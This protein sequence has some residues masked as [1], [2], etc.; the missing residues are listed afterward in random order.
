MRK[1]FKTKAYTKPFLL[2]EIKSL[3]LKAFLNA[4]TLISHLSPIKKNRS[5]KIFFLEKHMNISVK[6]IF[7]GHTRPKGSI[8]RDI[9]DRIRRLH[10]VND[11][12]A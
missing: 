4:D 7:V 6:D 2:K 9:L 10:W 8:R 12:L 5:A 1:K 3:P 11:R